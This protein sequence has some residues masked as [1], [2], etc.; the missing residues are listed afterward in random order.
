MLRFTE[1]GLYRAQSL[2][3]SGVVTLAGHAD[4]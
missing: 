3:A 1:L 2:Q 4:G